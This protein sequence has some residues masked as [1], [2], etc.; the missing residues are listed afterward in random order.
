LPTRDI[1]PGLPSAKDSE[2][3][4]FP[5][6]F[7]S[8]EEVPQYYAVSES[9]PQFSKSF[10]IALGLGMTFVIILLVYFLYNAHRQNQRL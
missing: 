7:E 1:I 8:Q 5:E 4:Y 6:V 3:V 2:I 9:E 10:F